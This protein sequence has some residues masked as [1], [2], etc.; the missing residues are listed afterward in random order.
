MA[1]DPPCP[2]SLDSSLFAL[3]QPWKVCPPQ[4]CSFWALPKAATL[5]CLESLAQW[6]E[7]WGVGRRGAESPS[8]LLGRSAV[9]LSYS[10]QLV[11]TMWPNP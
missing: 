7:E 8:T 11:T 5:P 9:S 6:G 2:Q 1:C 10:W 3:I 4:E